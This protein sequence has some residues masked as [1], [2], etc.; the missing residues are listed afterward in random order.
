MT[1]ARLICYQQEVGLVKS[2]DL[3]YVNNSSSVFKYWNYF[4]VA[5]KVGQRATLCRL[6][7]NRVGFYCSR[8]SYPLFKYSYQ[9]GLIANSV[10]KTQNCSS[11][12]ITTSFQKRNWF[13]FGEMQWLGAWKW[14]FV[15]PTVGDHRRKDCT[16]SLQST[17]R[18][19]WLE[20]MRRVFTK[21][22][23]AKASRSCL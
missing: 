16:W 14:D 13:Y 6:A 10:Q 4:S 1:F 21:T 12:S 17:S 15:K 18:Q 23:N 11:R 2:N 5:E 19:P 8:S 3:S 20:C 7:L 9:R 22:C